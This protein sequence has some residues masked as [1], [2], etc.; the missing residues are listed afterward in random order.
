MSLSLVK[1]GRNV[2][3]LRFFSKAYGLAG[4]RVGYGITTPEIVSLMG[5]PRM[6]FNFNQM[7]QIAATAALEDVEFIKKS[8]EVYKSG[9]AQVTE[10]CKKLNLQYEQPY[11]N[12]ILIKTGN[13][14]SVYE[15]LMMK[16]VIIRPVDAYKLPEWIRASITKEQNEK[17]ITALTDILNS[18]NN[19]R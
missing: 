10:T 8:K 17:F 3:V 18:K 4:L 2:I 7:A 11:V 15:K 14:K 9:I 6:P 16:G 1:Q 19:F 13:G 12:L 5:K